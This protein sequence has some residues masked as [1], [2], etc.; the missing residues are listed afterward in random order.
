METE[1]PVVDAAS[2]EAF[3]TNQVLD[4]TVVVVADELWISLSLAVV[5]D[6]AFVVVVVAVGAADD[7]GDDDEDDPNDDDDGDDDGWD[8]VD[9]G[10]AEADW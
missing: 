10:A 6:F 2:D 1:E 9:D 5:V 8:A 7:D 3:H 4:S